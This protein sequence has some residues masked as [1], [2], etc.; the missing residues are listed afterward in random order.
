MEEKPDTIRHIDELDNRV[1]ITVVEVKCNW[2]DKLVSWFK[3]LFGGNK[4]ETSRDS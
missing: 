1:E 4:H 3:N 2:D